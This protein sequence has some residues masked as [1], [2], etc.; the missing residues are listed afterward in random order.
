MKKLLIAA[1]ALVLFAQPA[2]AIDFTHKTCPIVGHTKTQK[3]YM[4]TSKMYKSMLR[5][6]HK[7][8]FRN[9][10]LNEKNAK[11]AGYKRAR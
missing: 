11:D 6:N 7:N 10:F 1:C 3:Y 9:C 2:M 4:P 5:D 8:D